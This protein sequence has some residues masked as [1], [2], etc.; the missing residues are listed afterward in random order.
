MKTL[1]SFFLVFTLIGLV[2]SIVLLPDEASAMPGFARKY[3]APC[4]SCHVAF[5]KLNEFGIAF[6]QRG[7]RMEKEGPGE[8][9]WKL[10]GI[11]IGGIAQA[12]YEFKNDEGAIPPA[13]KQSSK[14]EVTEVEFFYGGVLGPNI[15]F[16]GD[17]GADVA[18][19]ESLTPDVAFIIFDDLIS[20]SR[21]N[22]K[23]G[24][25]DVDFPFLSD[26]RSVTLSPYLVR[27]SA[28]P[29]EEGVTLGRRGAEVNGFLKNT[30]TR[31]A[32]G[33][34]NAKV[35]NSTNEFRAVHA[36][37]TETVELM[38]FN[39]TMGALVSLDQNG[40]K[41]AGTDNDTQAY[42]LALDLHYGLTG[43]VL[44]YYYYD[45]NKDA[46]VDPVRVVNSGLVELLHSFTQDLVGVV[47][48]D[49]QNS[50]GTEA[51]KNQFTGDL[52][53]FFHPNVRGQAEFSYLTDDDGLGNNTDVKTATLA[54][55]FGF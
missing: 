33:V 4:S 9:V 2:S 39:Q 53:Y 34:G 27:I 32:V 31:Y 16:F 5:P 36:W 12:A 22:L 25:F 55:T 8:P 18:A 7:Y 45:G 10:K 41:S 43:L 20:D 40:D 13:P 38:G 35:A 37:I 21:L 17:F 19:G 26:P 24:G 1:I 14:A 28:D 15:S 23:M 44:G 52:Q 6:R 50:A 54:V 51:S 46:T 29:T 11:P 49:F 30:A 48:Y 47:R 3:D 42:G